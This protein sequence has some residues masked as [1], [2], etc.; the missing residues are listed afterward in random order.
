[1]VTGSSIPK[2]IEAGFI[3]YS[4]EFNFWARTS[5]SF[6]LSLVFVASEDELTQLRSDFS[7]PDVNL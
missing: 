3:K 6:M 1:M 5:Q 2:S 7:R 4:S